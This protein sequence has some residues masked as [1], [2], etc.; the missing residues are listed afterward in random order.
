MRFSLPVLTS[1]QILIAENP[2]IGVESNVFASAAEVIQLGTIKTDALGAITWTPKPGAAYGSGLD[3]HVAVENPIN[4]SAAPVITLDATIVTVG[5]GT[6]AATFAVPSWVANQGNIYP[7]GIAFD[8]I[9]QGSGNALR[10][11]TAIAGVTSLANVPNNSELTVYGSPASSNFVEIGWKKTVDGAYNTPSSVSLAN[12]YNPSAAI[13]KGRPDVAELSMEFHHVSS[14]DGMC[15]YNG[16]RVSVLNKVIA[17]GS[18]TKEHI[19]YIGHRPNA[20]PKRGEGNDA[21]VESS[22]G[23]VVKCIRFVAL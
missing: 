2:E 13:K 10:L 1:A 5:T 4:G 6:L 15:R 21:V 12:G 9:P 17:D 23:P 19:L 3:V 18:V 8:M 14:M 22:S 16:M 20:T 11:V 7:Q